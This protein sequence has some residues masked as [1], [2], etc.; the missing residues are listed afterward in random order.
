LHVLK[1]INIKFESTLIENG[2]LTILDGKITAII[3][4]S[5]SGKSTLLYKAG[6]ISAGQYTYSFDGTTLDLN[7]DAELS[8]LRKT[9]IGYIFQD[10]NLIETLSLKENICLAATIAGY[11]VT[12]EDIRKYLIYVGLNNVNENSYPRQLSGGE[13]QR[14]AIAS[15]LAKKPDLIIADEPTS[16]LDE[17][18]AEAI[19]QIFQ[20]LAH[21]DGKKVIIATH[22]G[23]V[24]NQ[25]DVIY[26]IRDKKINLIKGQEQFASSQPG[27]ETNTF[28]SNSSPKLKMP[29]YLQYAKRVA[30]KG[31]VQRRIMLALCATAIAFSSAVYNFGDAFVARQEQFM[32]I[33][34]DREVLAVNMTAPF[35]PALDMEENLAITPT[36]AEAIYKISNVDE[37]YPYFE[38]TS[39]D[40]DV[41]NRAAALDASISVTIN[42]QRQEY[43]FDES[44]NDPFMDRFSLIPYFPEQNIT[45]RVKYKSNNSDG[46]YYISAQLAHVLHIPDLENDVTLHLTAFVPVALYDTIMNAWE[47][48]QRIPYSIDLDLS[49]MTEFEFKVAGILD[50]SCIN[51]YSDSGDNLIYA[52][53]ADMKA[54]MEGTQANYAADVVSTHKEWSPSAYVVFSK[55]YSDVEIVRGKLASINP[56]FEVISE[57]QDVEAMNTMIN[58]LKSG[59]LT[60]VLIVL[61]II[62]LLMAIIHM[63]SVL[64]RKYEIAL[65][66]ANG[67]T[68]RELFRLIMVES[69][70]YIS[71]VTIIA[72]IISMVLIAAVNFVFDMTLTK[73]SPNVLVINLL[74][75]LISVCIPTIISVVTINKYRPDAILRN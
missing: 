19:M 43:V 69:F 61:T 72:S 21:E 34:S 52:P 6:L 73:A 20:R 9:K 63:N 56:N 22:N 50:D 37:V 13:Q 2:C 59:A 3:G 33:I 48:E 60:I 28:L 42:G 57:Y 36:E 46:G 47:Q 40:Y 66:K 45:K 58:N 71:W 30:R 27:H 38:F 15:V 70:R 49:E 51:R 16:S 14:A 74:V 5:G 24:Y 55:S 68:R 44:G 11:D 65:L 17:G 1:D 39:V 75:A 29:F 32:N 67:L 4:E 35:Y 64:G 53:Y 10:N 8:Q 62:L 41:I 23:K 18:N 54:T 25:A 26:A 12:D 7:N 31:R